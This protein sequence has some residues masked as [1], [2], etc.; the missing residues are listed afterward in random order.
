MAKHGPNLTPEQHD[1]WHQK[2][3]VANAEAMKIRLGL[4][5][6][7]R[8]EGADYAF[9]S[10]KKKMVRDKR[11]ISDS[12]MDYYG[13]YSDAQADVRAGIAETRKLS[14][15]RKGGLGPDPPRKAKK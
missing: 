3:D 2:H 6:R 5:Q 8:N 13:G 10:V 7:D 9:D 12:G 14:A 4:A 1:A 15:T 11:T